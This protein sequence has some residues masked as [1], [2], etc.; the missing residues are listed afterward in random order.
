[1]SEADPRAEN[2]RLRQELA[3]IKMN[4]EFC[5]ERQPSSPHSG[6]NKKFELMQPEQG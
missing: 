6:A 3:E 5:Q 1:M 2:T 4:S